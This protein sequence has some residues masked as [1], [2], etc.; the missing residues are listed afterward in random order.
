M[1]NLGAMVSTNEVEEMIKEIDLD[2]NGKIDYEG[3]ITIEHYCDVYII[4][5]YV[6]V[7]ITN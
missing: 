5:I 3:S 4:Y 2:G 7:P 6:Y 1:R